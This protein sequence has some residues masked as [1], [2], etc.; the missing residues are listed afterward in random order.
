MERSMSVKIDKLLGKVESFE[1][2]AQQSL[3]AEAKKEKKLD[4]KAKVRNRGTVVVPAE[5]AKDKK[6]HFPINDEDQA[7][8]ALARVNQ[9]KK[10]PE[11]WSGS[12]QSLVN[13][14]TRKVHSKYPKIEISEEAKKPGKGGGKKKK[15]DFYDQLLVKL[16]Q[17]TQNQLGGEGS[18]EMVKPSDLP[19]GTIETINSLIQALDASGTPA[20]KA[21]ANNLRFY[22]QSGD[23]RG[24]NLTNLANALLNAAKSL[25]ADKNYQGQQQAQALY[26]KLLWNKT[27]SPTEADLGGSSPGRGGS[28]AGQE[29][30]GK[31]GGGQSGQ[32]GQAGR[33]S[34]GHGY[35]KIDP[36][37]QRAL[38]Y[39]GY[40][41]GSEKH[42]EGVDG[43]LGPNTRGAIDKYKKDAGVPSMSDAETF[44]AIKNE[45]QKKFPGMQ[46][47][48][49]DPSHSNKEVV[50][51]QPPP[52]DFTQTGTWGKK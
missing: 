45:Y 51:K 2:L 38:F 5:K 21:N 6:D 28:G 35:K 47:A 46:V 14:V 27:T 10:S 9:L 12:L 8:N 15:A 42:P 16:G 18:K 19:P 17:M 33:H 11:W 41:K 23:E 43:L 39:L 1:K 4:P 44:Q 40:L 50:Q 32:S 20:S 37:I 52:T 22:A 26:N 13:A 48:Y 29:G 3:V 24:F 49:N 36:Y 7:R 25:N 31:A 30:S 34:G